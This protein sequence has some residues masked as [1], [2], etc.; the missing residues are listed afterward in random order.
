MRSIHRRFFLTTT[1]SLDSIKKILSSPRPE[2]SSSG[3]QVCVT[4][5]FKSIREQK[6]YSFGELIDGSTASSL[7]LVWPTSTGV[8]QQHQSQSHSQG[9]STL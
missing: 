3:Y 8:L 4:G 9:F 1:S 2:I 7:Q 5:W 6:N